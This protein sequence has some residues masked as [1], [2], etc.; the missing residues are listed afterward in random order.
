M[1]KETELPT[2]NLNSPKFKLKLLLF[3]PNLPLFKI[4]NLLFLLAS[5]DPKTILLLMIER[6]L[7][8]KIKLPILKS[9]SKL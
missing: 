5:R 8:S 7:H 4:I 3:K 2:I 6:L 1:E 9:K